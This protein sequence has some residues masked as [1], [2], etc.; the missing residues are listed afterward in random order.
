MMNKFLKKSLALVLAAGLVFNTTGASI[1]SE[2]TMSAYGVSQQDVNA[3][4]TSVDGE[5][6]DLE[7][8]NANSDATV[9]GNA[10][11]AGDTAALLVMLPEIIMLLQMQTAMQTQTA[12]LDAN[13]NTDANN[14]ASINSDSRTYRRRNAKIMAATA[15]AVAPANEKSR[16]QVSHHGTIQQLWMV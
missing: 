6:A 16:S 1:A 11:A 7:S 2:D 15:G 9:S 4:E 10:T 14:D 12:T 5:T 8:S 3:A 13:G